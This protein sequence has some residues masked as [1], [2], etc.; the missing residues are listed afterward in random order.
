MEEEKAY[1][2]EDERIVKTDLVNPNAGEYPS[3]VTSV[4]GSQLRDLDL[5]RL[6]QLL[7]YP[8][9]R[10]GGPQLGIGPPPN[11]YCDGRPIGILQRG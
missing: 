11:G 9:A 8:R 7:L 5:P 10:P 6:N 1:M 4:G 3:G 2:F